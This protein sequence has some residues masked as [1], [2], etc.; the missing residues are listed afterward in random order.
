[1][2]LAVV[3]TDEQE[4]FLG[5]VVDVCIDVRLTLCEAHVADLQGCISKGQLTSLDRFLIDEEV[6][7]KSGWLPLLVLL[8][9]FFACLC[10][11]RGDT[12]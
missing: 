6:D 7:R 3:A 2:K 4:V 8:F 9:N 10:E 1:M 11:R 12:R 5:E